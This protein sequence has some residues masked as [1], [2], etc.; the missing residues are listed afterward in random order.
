MLC[1][2]DEEFEQVGEQLVRDQ[3]GLGR[4]DWLDDGST[5]FNQPHGERIKLL[6]DSGFEI[7][8]L[9]ELQVPR[10]A[11]TRYTFISADWASRWPCEEIW[12]ARKS[13]QTVDNSAA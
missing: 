11:P 5:E 1:S 6:R 10:D 9:H 3:F 13:G 12:L 2:P 8:A 4:I 7:E